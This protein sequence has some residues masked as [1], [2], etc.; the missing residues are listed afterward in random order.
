[1]MSTEEKKEMYSAKRMPV[2]IYD[3]KCENL[4]LEFEMCARKLGFNDK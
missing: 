4:R 2:P 1:M 3:E